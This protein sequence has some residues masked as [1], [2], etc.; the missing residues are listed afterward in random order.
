MSS[1]KI[2]LVYFSP[3]GGTRKIVE[4]IAKGLAITP[5]N[6]IDLTKNE[7][8]KTVI[9]NDSVT[10]IGMP[11]YAGRLPEVAVERLH[12]LSSKGGFI[13]PVVSYGNRAYEDALLELHDLTTAAGFKTLAA[14]AFVAE[15]SFS[16]KS[17][18]IA[19]GRPNQADKEAAFKFGQSVAGLLKSPESHTVP[20]IPGHRPYK[21][22]KD[23]AP[24]SPATDAAICTLCRRC[25]E[26]CP[27]N[28]ITINSTVETN[29]D[30]CIWC[31][32]CIKSCPEDARTF[33][34]PTIQEVTNRL[35]TNCQT[36]LKPEVFL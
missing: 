14:G 36:P 26:V 13:V 27:T 24:Q 8:P 4:T 32:A 22:R 9:D 33:N 1:K 17:Y 3:T 2:N 29:K 34:T 15:H 19:T 28:A 21:P 20:A 11:V 23:S 7:A 10:I 12:Q 5:I 6:L 35:F 30:L 16:T 25:E 31:C 18:P